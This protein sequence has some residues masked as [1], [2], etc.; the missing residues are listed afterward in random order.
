MVR[1]LFKDKDGEIRTMNYLEICCGSYEDALN[2]YKGNA[3]R[4]ELNSA[5][6]L[7][8]LTPSL[9]TF[10]LAKQV[11]NI[12]IICMI[13]PRGA[14]FKYTKY[15]IETMFEDA[16]IFLENGVDGLAFGFL[17]DDY[18]IDIEN[19]K[20]MV[21]LIH[22]YNKEAVFHRAFD[23]SN[24]LKKSIETLIE[25]KVDRVLT[26]GGYSNVTLG[27]DN[28]KKLSEYQNKIEILMG[29]G[30]NENNVKEIIEYTNINQVHSSAK[31]WIF[32]NTTGNDKLNYRFVEDNVYDIVDLNKVIKLKENIK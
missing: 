25:L 30:I 32:D 26:S 1:R 2:A 10:K 13:R 6:H 8:G 18:S 11:I 15:E 29:S 22:S 17:N 24:D 5:L 19:T 4:I 16:K 28:L 12:P 3:D 31:S 20:K 21:D 9:A 23:I 14:G 27:K 7:G